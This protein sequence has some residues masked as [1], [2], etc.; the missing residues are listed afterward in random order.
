MAQ[1]AAE[2]GRVI[3]GENGVATALAAIDRSLS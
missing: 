2:L 3:Q 1:R